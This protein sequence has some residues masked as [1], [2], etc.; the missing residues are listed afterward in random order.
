MLLR[1]VAL[2]GGR[3]D[4]ALAAVDHVVLTR[5]DG[6]AYAEIDETAA[7]AFV[8]SLAYA[9]V[10]AEPCPALPS[11]TP[12]ALAARGVDLEPLPA[13]THALDT[14]RLDRVALGL[15]TRELLRPR[16]F[17]LLGPAERAL[18]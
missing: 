8:R 2:S 14:L 3:V 16:L 1:L 13:G 5:R 6:A 18:L 15:V 17:G 11:L 4:A 10:R 9:G 12:A 7:A